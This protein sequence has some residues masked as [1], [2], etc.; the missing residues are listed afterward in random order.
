MAVQFKDNTRAVMAKYNADKAK[1]LEAMGL[2]AEAGVKPK[3]PVDTGNLRN[4]IEHQTDTA[5]DQVIVG[6]TQLDPPYSIYQE[7]GTRSQPAQPYLRPGVL[8]N[9]D[10]IRQAFINQYKNMG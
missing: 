2:A 6:S 9:I 4:S 5:N 7:L 8:E 3:V 10:K 1:G